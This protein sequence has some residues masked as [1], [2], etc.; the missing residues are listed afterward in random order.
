MKNNL[1]MAA[2]LGMLSAIPP[3]ST[4]MYIQAFPLI[5]RDFAAAETQVQLSLTAMLLGLACG[6]I[7]AGPLSDVYG[8]KK[9]LLFSLAAFALAS[10][11][12]AVAATIEQFVALRF[13]Q[14]LAGSGG[15]VI[16]RAIAYDK[17]HGPVLTQFIAMLMVI[18]NI[19]PIFA[20]VLG[21]Q[22]LSFFNWHYIFM[23]LALCGLILF[24]GSSFTLMETLPPHMRSGSSTAE[25]AKSFFSLFKNKP[26]TACL[27]V[28][29]LFLGGL[30]AYISASPFVL[31]IIYGLTPV[32][33]SL[34]FGV[35]GIAMM[36]AVKIAASFVMRY[37]ERTQL[38]AVLLIYTFAGAL[39]LAA[40]FSEQLTLPLLLALLFIITACI[41][42]GE[43]NSFS[44]AMQSISSRAGSAAGLLGIGSFLLGAVVSPL[45]GI[46]GASAYPM[47]II[48]ILSGIL[49]LVAL[50]HIPLLKR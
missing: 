47:G 27:A 40:L 18:N 36:L 48:L 4:D 8:R 39:L 23:F 3:L 7:F 21:G 1:K 2:L 11:G 31:Q 19:A 16:S 10:C 46:C 30:F 34:V 28:H 17:Y 33:C 14:G 25:I 50:H 44:L 42:V 37:N 22:I 26:Y 20:P 12:C 49:S 13:I 29:C 6:Q 32:Q 24:C 15:V 41:S 5:G 43:C 45:T 9:P 38:K 35:N